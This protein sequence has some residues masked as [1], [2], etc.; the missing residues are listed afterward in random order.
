MH[1]PSMNRAINHSTINHPSSHFGINI[2]PSASI[3][4]PPNHHSVIFFHPRSFFQLSKI[5][6]KSIQ[7]LS[8][9]L[10]QSSSIHPY[11]ISQFFFRSI[12]SSISSRW[13]YDALKSRERIRGDNGA[14][15]TKRAL[16]EAVW[17]ATR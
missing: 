6:P 13:G 9:I 4:S 11:T 10:P 8:K 5:D 7:N 14:Q 17:E 15:M 16:V 2:H 1:Q 3:Q 12:L